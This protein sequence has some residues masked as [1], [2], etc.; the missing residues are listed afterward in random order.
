MS[1]SFPARSPLPASPVL[2]ASSSAFS[3]VI[4]Y[5]MNSDMTDLILSVYPGLS[6]LSPNTLRSFL[7]LE[8]SIPI[9]RLF[10]MSSS[11]VMSDANEPTS[12]LILW[13]SLENDRTSMFSIPLLGELMTSSCWVDRPN[14][15]GTTT[16]YCLSGFFSA[17]SSMNLIRR[18]L[19]SLE[20]PPSQ[21]FRGMIFPLRTYCQ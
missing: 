16:R 18:R 2:R 5:C 14:C 12:S 20:A 13:A 11:V 8:A 7:C 1:D 17:S 19:L 4:P 6:R 10:P 15:S 9:R 21:N 3:T